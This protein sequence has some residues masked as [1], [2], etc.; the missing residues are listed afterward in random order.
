VNPA[1]LALFT[2]FA[3]L[4]YLGVSPFLWWG[5]AIVGTIFILAG[6]LYLGFVNNAGVWPDAAASDNRG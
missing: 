5:F 2:I 1:D 3:G 6:G 4:L